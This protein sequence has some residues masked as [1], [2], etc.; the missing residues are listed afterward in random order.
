[1]GWRNWSAGSGGQD[2]AFAFSV[3]TEDDQRHV[4]EPSPQAAA[5][6]AALTRASSVLLWDPED[7]TLIA[8]NLVGDWLPKD[9]SADSRT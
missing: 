1:M 7:R 6:L 5:V 4:I 2:G 8:A 3:V 9:W